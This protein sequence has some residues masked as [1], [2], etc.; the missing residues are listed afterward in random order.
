MPS[1]AGRRD[2]ARE[3]DIFGAGLGI[4]RGV[5]VDDDQ[6]DGIHAD[7]GRE[8]LGYAPRFNAGSVPL[9]SLYRPSAAAELP[10]IVSVSVLLIPPSL[11]R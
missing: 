8:D 3:R 4:V 1:R 9:L 7:R 10:L 6:A 2:L 5:G 11:W